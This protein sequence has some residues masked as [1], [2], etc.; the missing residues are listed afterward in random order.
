MSHSLDSVGH[1]V[2]PYDPFAGPA[3]S[4]SIA[5]TEAQREI[6]TGTQMGRDAS[7]AFNEAVRLRLVGSLDVAALRTALSQLIA[8]H[9]SL[10]ATF[11]PDGLTMFVVDAVALD[12]PLRDFSSLDAHARA[13]ALQSLLTNVVSDAFD[14][15]HGP[16]LRGEL[17]RI[18]ADEHELVLSAHHIV[19]DG[20]SWGVIAT[21]LSTLYTAQRTGSAA[22]LPS[23]ERFSDYSREETAAAVAQARGD[24]QRYWTQQ[25]AGT[26]PVLDLPGD[27]AR[28]LLKTYVSGREDYLISAEI[29]RAVKVAGAKAGSSMFATLL[30][31]YATLMHRLSGHDDLVIGVPSAGQS[32][33]G[34]EGL[35]GHCVNMLPMRIRADAT[36]GADAL[37]AQVRTTSLDAFEHQGIGFGKL[38]ELLPIL[39]DPSRLP[40]VSVI[41]N[42]DRTMPAS[43]MP[44]DGLKPELLSVP[45]VCENFD[46]FVNA[47][48]GDAGIT[49]ECQYNGD[50]FDASTVRRWLASY[51]QLLASFAAAPHTPIGKL[52]ILAEADRA[53]LAR[54]N[55]TDLDVPRDVLVHEMVAAQSVRT[56]DAVAVEFNGTP[57]S[58]AALDARAN[59]LAHLLRRRGASR[60]SLVG[61]CLDRTPELLIGVLAILKCGAGYVPLDPNYPQD[62]LSFMATDAALKV[63]L[64][65]SRIAAELSLDAASVV[66]L[67]SDASELTAQPTTAL[68]RDEL[69][70]GPEDTAYAI[71]T[72]GSTGKPKG[73]LVPHRSVVNLLASVQREPGLTS[74]DTM[75]AITTLS[76]DIAV[77]ELILPLTVGARIV[78][79][80]RETASDGALLQQL[81]EAR[82]VTFIDATP[83]TYRL[84]L[85][86]GWR[87]SQA[88]R[89]ICTGEAMPKDLAQ[90]LTECAREV[91]NG[92]GPTETTV[93]STFARITAPVERVLIGFPVANTRIRI[94]DAQG[95]QVPIGV[96]GEMLIGGRGVTRGYL[97]RPDLTA[98]KFL[99]STHAPGQMEYR[100]GDLVRLLPNGELECLGRKDNQVKVRGLDRKS[101]V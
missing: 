34:H 71:Y 64:T 69:A 99:P 94:V 18:A 63:L 74:A 11:S 51:E 53:A 12:L 55:Q 83:V 9:E 68:P 6:W 26:L 80:S 86:A 98:E 58:Y 60:G 13:R 21:E 93:W 47:V 90:T 14:L 28:P 31:G 35:I 65:D 100:T 19:C 33:S 37:L 23:A 20:W 32:A 76:F 1:G 84:L 59:Q 4:L 48:D 2:V 73:V 46:L 3:I 101:V 52:V 67:D 88:L 29:V 40:L 56:P 50:L 44:F 30:S 66:H 91:W 87:G 45:R 8:R 39:R 24:D 79:S 82:G 89:V 16:L 70:A 72:S 17:V 36:M 75:L 25:F 62:R 38:L 61:V 77:S 92:Y 5:S 43:A 49:L 10:H 97:N 96:A 27:R 7:L 22:V 78:L 95:E 42:L 81:I 54:C 15:E 57:L 41:F 85:A